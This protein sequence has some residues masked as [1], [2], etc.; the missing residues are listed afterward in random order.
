MDHYSD[1]NGSIFLSRVVAYYIELMQFKF[2]VPWYYSKFFIDNAI[3][4][5]VKWAIFALCALWLVKA[6]YD[7]FLVSKYNIRC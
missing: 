5:E 7:T 2:K 3:L 4:W 1:K 6:D